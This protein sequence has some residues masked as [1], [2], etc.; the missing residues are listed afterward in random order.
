[1]NKG[2]PFRA[3]PLPTPGQSGPALRQ[4]MP[5][6][7]ISSHRK[8]V[9]PVEEIKVEHTTRQK[10]EESQP[11]NTTAI[12]V[13]RF[14]SWSYSKLRPQHFSKREEKLKRVG[15]LDK[16]SVY[17]IILDKFKER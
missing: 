13:T 10:W 15:L 7:E 5:I 16:T 2:H 3:Q 11:L 9:K 12:L 1:M 6:L 8:R 4:G 14:L 17:N